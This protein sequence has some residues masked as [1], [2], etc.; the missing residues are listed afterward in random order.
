MSRELALSFASQLKALEEFLKANGNRLSPEV[1]FA[2]YVFDT[3]RQSRPPI[4]DLGSLVPE[5]KRLSEA[6]VLAATGYF[7]SLRSMSVN[8]PSHEDWRAALKKLSKRE[9]FPADRSAFSY[10]PLEVLGI[11]LGS[12]SDGS[13]DA[14]SSAW[15]GTVLKRLLEQEQP[16]VWTQFL[17]RVAAQALAV[18]ATRPFRPD[19]ERLTIPEFAL[20]RWGSN[21]LKELATAYFVTDGFVTLDTGLLE[22][23]LTV[24]FEPRDTAEA[25]VVWVA[26]RAAVTARLESSLANTW[27]VGRQ[28][29]DAFVLVESICRRFPLFARQLT[30]RHEYRPGFR[31]KDEYDV[32]DLLHALL[33]LHFDDVRA[34]EVTPSYAGNS[35]RMDFLL[36]G[37]QLVVEAKMTRKTLRQKEVANQLIEDK[38]R[39]R[40]HPDCRTLVCLVYDPGGYCDN[41]IALEKDISAGSGEPR[42]V[43]IVVPRGL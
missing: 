41:P 25:A 19:L 42:V 17:Y 40:T 20:L 12:V 11:C 3:A 9:P 24:L 8:L 35:S 28:G 33:L 22:R 43:A 21:L 13:P 27:Q 7:R 32:Q 38:E 6:P 18:S 15:L 31:I 1:G 16:D 26:I 23:C 36:K 5:P 10:R 37:E 29:K 34:E 2:W 4:G 39:Y 14:Q 30:V